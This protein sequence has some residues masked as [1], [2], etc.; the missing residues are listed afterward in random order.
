[1]EKEGDNHEEENSNL[2]QDE[3]DEDDELVKEIDGTST[4][5]TYS[6]H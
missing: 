3:I 5:Y 4:S 2:E 1:M 6:F